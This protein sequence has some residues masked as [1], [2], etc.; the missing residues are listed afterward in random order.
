MNPDGS[1]EGQQ[2]QQQLKSRITLIYCLIVHIFDARRRPLGLPA[3][4][5]SLAVVGWIRAAMAIP[6]MPNFMPMSL[7][8]ISAVVSF[9]LTLK[10]ISGTFKR[11]GNS[12]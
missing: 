7:N 10:D 2:Q 5:S 11:I 8:D 1:L 4:A 12:P 9:S 6:E 3:L